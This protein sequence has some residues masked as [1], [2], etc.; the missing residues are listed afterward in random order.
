MTIT[1]AMLSACVF[2]EYIFAKRKFKIADGIDAWINKTPAWYPFNP[3]CL[4]IKNAMQ[5]PLINL[6]KAMTTLDLIFFA[7]KVLSVIPSEVK[8]KK[9]VE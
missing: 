6:K 2:F 7:F 5:G 1:D 3:K 9:I 8:T 4:I